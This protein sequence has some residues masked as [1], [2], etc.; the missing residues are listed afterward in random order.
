[1]APLNWDNIEIIAE[2]ESIV[3]ITDW[4][5][6]EIVSEDG[7]LIKTCDNDIYNIEACDRMIVFSGQPGAA[8]TIRVGTVTTLPAGSDA[9]VTNSGTPEDAIFDFGIPKGAD[10]ASEWGDIGGTLSD[11]TDLQN[12]LNAKANSADLGDL[13]SKDSVDYLTEVTNKPTLGTMAAVN[14]ASSDSKLYGRKNGAWSEVPTPSAPEWGDIGGT[15]ADQTDLANALAA[16]ANTADLGTLASQNKVDW[17]TDIDDIPSTF[18]PSSHTHGNITNGG[19][20]SSDTAVASGD[21]LVLADASD[22]SKLIRS[23]I[24]FD[25]STT[26]KGLTPKGTWESFA[27]ASHNHDD[28]YYTE[29]EIDN[30]LVLKANNSIIAD[31]FSTSTA[32]AV[33][34]YVI[35]QGVLYRFT[36]AHSAGAWASGDV[37][38]V[39]VGDELEG[40]ANTADLGNLATQNTV[41]YS[42]EVTNK[43]TLGTL[44]SKSSVDYSTSEVTN[45][46]TLG[47]MS[48]VND[49]PSDGDEYVR[50]NGAWAIASG[51]GGGGA[52]PDIIADEFNTSTA[53][54][55]GDLV[56][57][58]G[59]LYKFTSAHAAGA[60]DSSEVS[61]ITVDDAMV[62]KTGDTMTGDLIITESPNVNLKMKNTSMDYTRNTSGSAAQSIVRFLD[63][64][65]NTAGAFQ[66]YQTPE[67]YMQSEFA[68]QKKYNNNTYTNKI[69]L[70]V[71]NTGTYQV[72]V[73]AASAWR[74]ALGLTSMATASDS[75]WKS[76]TNTS[77][78][79]G[80]IYY[81]KIGS[82]ME[83]TANGLAL[84]ADRDSSG[85]TTLKQLG[86]GYRP[87]KQETVS[88]TCNNVAQRG[89][90]VIET[91]G[92]IKISAESGTTLTTS[93]SISFQAFYLV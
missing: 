62:K 42:T 60:W 6:V 81:R 37:T 23:E 66:T 65:E 63:Y 20:I 72:E 69:I 77:V 28:R 57:H 59:G 68:V 79:T 83:V 2:D 85:W 67:G 15:L 33:G 1:M 52:D 47:T 76:L 29:T 34:D 74:T 58:S 32:Y 88:F 75:G 26:T 22:S 51:G 55:I 80:A 89:L 49:A 21:K 19:A 10:G 50:K 90:I 7:D 92:N 24:S 91:G 70:R 46:P 14:D 48:A 43:P 41:D 78:F 25:G 61:S 27:A 31:A 4:S 56:I 45:K 35:Y 86:S 30:S 8:A 93:A 5:R 87:A 9:T 54:A 71:L 40:K 3:R 13:A 39:V 84:V 82:M 38:A 17:D 44:A 16:K 36:S 12:A 64:Q 11:Q 53:Y 18:P 73:T